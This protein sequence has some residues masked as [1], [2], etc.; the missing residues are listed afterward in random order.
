M[1]PQA[2]P[3]L[4]LCKGCAD[5]GV[6]IC[7]MAHTSLAKSKRAYLQSHHLTIEVSTTTILPKPR[8]LTT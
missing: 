1:S 4:S 3:L 8:F 6:S 7:A 2:S 5:F